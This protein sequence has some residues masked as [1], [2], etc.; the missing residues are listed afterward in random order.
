[1]IYQ[2][3]ALLCTPQPFWS[4]NHIARFSL[5]VMQ[6]CP[7]ALPLQSHP[8]PAHVWPSHSASCGD[9]QSSVHFVEMD[10]IC[11]LLGCLLIVPN[12]SHSQKQTT[13]D[14]KVCCIIFYFNHYRQKHAHSSNFSPSFT[15][16]SSLF[17][18]LSIIPFSVFIKSDFPFSISFP[19]CVLNCVFF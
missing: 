14:I 6:I 2:Q 1:M 16:F 13:M 7:P 3:N 5:V 15:W 19:T 12:I 9:G 18:S 11:G 8:C 10:C 17:L 4:H